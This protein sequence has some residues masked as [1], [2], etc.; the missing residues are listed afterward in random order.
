MGVSKTK[1]Y[2]LHGYWNLE[3]AD[4]VIVVLVTTNEGRAISRLETIQETKAVE[5]FDFP[6]N[7]TVEE[8]GERLY[9]IQDNIRAGNY[10]KFYITE[11][12]VEVPLEI[13]SEVVSFNG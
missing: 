10:A 5:F 11:H 1:V 13:V 6:Y 4:G 8:V 12:E 2:V 7:D 3:E 9:E